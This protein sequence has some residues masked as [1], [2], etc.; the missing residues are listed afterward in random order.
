[1]GLRVI[2]LWLRTFTNVIFYA[3]IS[4]IQDQKTTQP[5]RPHQVYCTLSALML[6]ASEGASCN[7]SWRGLTRVA[8][9]GQGDAR[10]RAW[11]KREVEHPRLSFI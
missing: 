9:P 5:K 2:F 8:Y 10:A 6:C 7:M 3:R 11:D 4:Q 1:M